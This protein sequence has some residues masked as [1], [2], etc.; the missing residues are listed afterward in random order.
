MIN[1]FIRLE[2]QKHINEYKVHRD[3]MQKLIP[4]EKWL[5]ATVGINLERNC[6]RTL[7]RLATGENL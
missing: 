7:F 5:L 1:I 4:A 3:I 2:E 6:N